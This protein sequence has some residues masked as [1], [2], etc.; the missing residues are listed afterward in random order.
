MTEAGRQCGIYL[1]PAWHSGGRTS[2]C[3]GCWICCCASSPQ[4]G[5]ASAASVFW[6][7][8]SGSW[9]WPTPHCC[10]LHESHAQEAS[11][12]YATNA[13]VPLPDI[14]TLIEWWSD[15]FGDK[16][17]GRC[18]YLQPL[19]EGLSCSELSRLKAFELLGGD[20][21]WEFELWGERNKEFEIS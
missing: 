18:A 7:A 6:S 11:Q 9:L 4:A 1:P 19:V 13:G 17:G 5:E 20:R 12:I 8:P 21:L 3:S 14:G 16:S 2:A 10:K 15:D